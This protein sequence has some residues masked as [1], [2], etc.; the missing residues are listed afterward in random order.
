MYS[1]VFVVLH[2]WGPLP[3]N[4]AASVVGTVLGTELHRRLTFRSD[5]RVGWATAQWQSMGVAAVGL[6]ATTVVLAAVEVLVP[7]ST[8]WEEVL[9]VNATTGL[10]GIGRYVV[11]RSWVFRA[12]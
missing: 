8:W 7:G 1:L 11:L 12:G 5:P 4:V 9:V 6:V 2:G 10:I 3:A